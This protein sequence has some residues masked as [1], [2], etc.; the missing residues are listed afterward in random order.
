MELCL[1][2]AR[3]SESS[4][5]GARE[6]LRE[7]QVDISSSV[8]SPEQMVRLAMV[9]TALE[10]IHSCCSRVG[11][12]AVREELSLLSAELVRER[13]ASGVAGTARTQVSLTTSNAVSISLQLSERLAA[14]NRP[15]LLGGTTS[16]GGY[17]PRAASPRL[18]A[19]SPVSSASGASPR[20]CHAATVDGGGSARERRA[21]GGARAAHHRPLSPPF[22]AHSLPPPPPS[23]VAAAVTASSSSAAAVGALPNTQFVPT[24]D[25]E[26]RSHHSNAPAVLARADAHAHK[27]VSE[28]VSKYQFRHAHG[29]QMTSTHDPKAMVAA[30]ERRRRSMAFGNQQSVANIAGTRKR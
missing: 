6:Q 21:S 24:V 25:G 3:V 4:L 18:S 23:A 7:E 9:A 29:P 2:L 12:E 15:N 26:F 8:A 17:S 1:P 13:A 30:K 5:S 20:H 14:S 28:A 19:S 11:D 27:S 22:A 10:L 16:S